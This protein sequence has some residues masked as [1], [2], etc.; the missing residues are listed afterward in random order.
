MVNDLY[1][2]AGHGSGQDELKHRAVR[3]TYTNGLLTLVEQ[4]NVN[5]QSDTDWAA[6]SSLQ[7]VNTGYDSNARPVARNLVAGSTV[8]AL[9]Q[10]SYDAL[11]R[12]DCVAQRMNPAVFATSPPPPAASAPRGRGRT[13]SGRTASS[14]RPMMRRGR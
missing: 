12:P 2:W 9:T 14:G 11:G 13:T 6:F 7:A 10:M 4:G 8:H 3:N 5:S 1:A